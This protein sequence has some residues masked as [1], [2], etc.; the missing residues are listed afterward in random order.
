L[1]SR[2]PLKLHEPLQGNPWKK[3]GK[4]L[5]GVEIGE[6]SQGDGEMGNLL[7][8]DQTKEIPNRQSGLGFSVPR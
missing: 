7:F 3:F 5:A 6:D 4:N 2:N 1:F 8:S